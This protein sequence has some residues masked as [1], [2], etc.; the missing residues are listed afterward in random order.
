M[1]SEQVIGQRIALHAVALAACAREHLKFR[2]APAHAAPLRAGVSAPLQPVGLAGWLVPRSSSCGRAA[3]CPAQ[4]GR[5]PAMLRAAA[6]LLAEL[7][8]CT[9]GRRRASACDRRTGE[10]SQT[11]W[12]RECCCRPSI[13]TWLLRATC[14]KRQLRSWHATW[15]LQCAAAGP[16]GAAL[17]SAR[18]AA[19]EPPPSQR[20]A[21]PKASRVTS[22]HLEPLR[23]TPEPSPDASPA[24]P[25][26]APRP[27]H[28]NRGAR[29]QICMAAKG[30]PA[31]MQ[32]LL[33]GGK[34]PGRR[35]ELR[36]FTVGKAGAGAMWHSVATRSIPRP[37]HCNS[38][39]I[40]CQSLPAMFCCQLIFLV[41]SETAHSRWHGGTAIPG[42]R[43]AFLWTARAGVGWV[44]RQTTEAALSLQA[45]GAHLFASIDVMALEV[46]ECEKLA[47]TSM[48]IEFATH[49]SRFLTLFWWAPAPCTQPQLGGAA[50]L[51][52]AT[53]RCS[54]MHSRPFNPPCERH[55]APLLPPCGDWQSARRYHAAA[56]CEREHVAP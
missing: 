1:C 35:P 7:R 22:S 50:A 43:I 46:G 55:P 56:N 27:R 13:A 51:Q 29:R 28:S 38:S 37:C 34:R 16:A 53:A 39:K 10:T 42:A 11:W 52:L 48:P 12:S 9:V 4:P 21:N 18:R 8:I 45:A 33:R 49:T 15:L 24:C 2:C 14:R 40:L 31:C 47:M 26:P 5:R 6:S 44:V 17:C 19:R 20:E 36:S 30:K 3:S 32:A 23:A 54:S 41:E 25:Q